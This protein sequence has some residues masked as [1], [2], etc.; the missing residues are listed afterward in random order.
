MKLSVKNWAEF[1][2][3]KNRRPPWIKLH[4][5]L[6]DD[7]KFHCLPVASRALAPCLWLIASEFEDGI[8]DGSAEELAY[9]LRQTPKQIQEALTPL[10]DSG[11]FIVVQGASAALAERQQVAVPETEERHIK[12]T[13]TEPRFALPDWV[14]VE[15]WEAWI[16]SRKGKTTDAA[17]KLNLRELEKLKAEGQDPKEVL[18]QSI[19]RGWS[20]LFPIKS[21]AAKPAVTPAWWSSDTLMEAK[22]RELNIAT[23]G[24]TRD[25]LR[26]KINERLAA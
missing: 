7:R 1:Q 4:H 19:M 11:F 9:R 17:K 26:G 14:P 15:T 6:L 20:G 12:H 22:A 3:Y 18:E 10:I 23:R 21:D 13:E 2:H 8:F 16:K 24:L 5:D 25:Q